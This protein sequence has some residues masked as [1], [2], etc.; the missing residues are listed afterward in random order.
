MVIFYCIQRFESFND[1]LS[2]LKESNQLW[3]KNAGTIGFLISRRFFKTK[4]RENQL[5]D[6]DCGASWM[7]LTIQAR[8]LGYF[9]HGMGGTLQDR[10]RGCSSSM[11]HNTRLLWA[12][13]WES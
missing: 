12:S 8:L 6:F 9:T 5:A 2:C 11:E 1:F 7:A 10:M 4:D 13:L 3:A